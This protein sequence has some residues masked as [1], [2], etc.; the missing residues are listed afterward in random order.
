MGYFVEITG[1][2]SRNEHMVFR[3]YGGLLARGPPALESGE[4]QRLLRGFTR[5]ELC[6]RLFGRSELLAGQSSLIGFETP[7]H[8]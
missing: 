2:T 5:L 6:S 3:N 1:D 4:R 8:R 7:E